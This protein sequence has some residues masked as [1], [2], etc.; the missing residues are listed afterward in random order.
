MGT[1]FVYNQN[2][3]VNIIRQMVQPALHRRATLRLLGYLYDSLPICSLRQSEDIFVPLYRLHR[4]GSVG[5]HLEGAY[6]MYSQLVGSENIKK[7]FQPCTSYPN[8]IC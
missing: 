2:L 1:R 3:I 7:M 5:P 8:W 6:G 4:V